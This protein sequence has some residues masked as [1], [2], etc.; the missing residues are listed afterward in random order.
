MSV[1]TNIFSIDDL[2]KYAEKDFSSKFN[3]T[4]D[5]L[6]T[7]KKILF[8]TTSNRFQLKDKP[9]DIPKS[10]QIAMLLQ[11]AL[12]N[13]ATIIDGSKLNI[14][15]CEGNVSRTDGN[16]CG[17][18]DALLK[19]KEKNPSGYLRCWASLNNKEDE[20]WR[21]TKPLFES[22]CIVFFGSIRWGQTNS[23]YQKIIERL[24]WIENRHT[25]L[26]EN[27]IVK[28]IDSGC[29]FTGHNFNG[30]NV[31]ELQKNVM[32]FYGFKTPSQLFWNRQW[33]NDPSEESQEGYAKDTNDFNKE[34]KLTING[35]NI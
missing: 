16:S 12:E 28:N 1:K 34:I 13:K 26:K 23:V 25:T 19:D 21:I 24:C 20:L 5:Y 15:I 33:A 27:N 14:Y 32:N 30:S 9:V 8:V 31:I 7:K 18:K 29:I 6:K 22:D 35:K 10:T 17:T 4:L 3:Q 2:L 11:R